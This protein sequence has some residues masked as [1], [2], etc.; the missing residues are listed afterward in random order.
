MEDILTVHIP[1]EI[2]HTLNRTPEEM[3]RDIRLYS[4]LMLFRLGKLSSGTASVMAGIPRVMFLDLCSEYDIPV[5]QI[6]TE[7]LQ[8]EVSGG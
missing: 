7:E 3:E 4:A 5:S 6:T 1:N 8:R 2:R